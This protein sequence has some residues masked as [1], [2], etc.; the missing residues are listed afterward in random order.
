MSI[1]PSG[2]TV[3]HDVPK[4]EPRPGNRAP[5]GAC[6]LPDVAARSSGYRVKADF[7]EVGI[8]SRQNRL[9]SPY[10]PYI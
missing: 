3:S 6:Q 7:L 5:G 8:G 4:A 2:A 9:P 1:P 10:R